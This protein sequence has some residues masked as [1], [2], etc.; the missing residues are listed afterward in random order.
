[1][2]LA[3]S[4]SIPED[5]GKL[6][7]F[8]SVGMDALFESI[9]VQ[10]LLSSSD[11]NDPTTPLSAPDLR[12]LIQRLESHSLQIKTKIQSY[13]LT[14]HGDFFN[15]FTLCNDAISRSNQISD[16][17]SDL[18]NL[19]SDSLVD[20][21]ISNTVK[22]M[23][24]KSREMRTKKELL[25]LVR[26][27]VGITEKLSRVKE[28][29]KSGRLRFVAEELKQVKESLRISDDVDQ[30]S[31]GEPIVYG[32]LRNEWSACFEEVKRCFAIFVVFVCMI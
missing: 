4:F 12:L 8:D 25:E 7:V 16:D 5:L 10:D 26:A 32:L 24:A 30:V 27:I 11:L 21:E 14:H 6:E 17:F 29:M 18:L 3:I 15:L 2:L 31:E 20:I 19:I 9:K 28:D 23:T 22:E 13:L 1:M